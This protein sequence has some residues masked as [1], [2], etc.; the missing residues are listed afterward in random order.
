MKIRSLLLIVFACFLT[1]SSCKSKEEKAAEL[2]KQELAKTLYDFESYEPIET[3][4][5]EAYATAYN[6][7]ICYNM[8]LVI[9]YEFSKVNEAIEKAK[10]ACEYA[11][12]WGA[13]TAYSSS[14]SDKKYYKYRN[15]AKEQLD[16]V[17][18]GMAIIKSLGRTLQD[19]IAR[20]DENKQIGW[21]V[22]HRFRC[23]TR[24]GQAS[25]GDYRYVIANN[26]KKVLLREDMDDEDDKRAR[27]MIKSA[28]EGQF[29]EDETVKDDMVVVEE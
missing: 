22:K 11:D 18:N 14:Y 7:S 17:D 5:T 10:E 16:K 3:T 8:A 26:F 4:V 20:L 29:T 23:K 9:G 27:S 19:S 24:G 13:P 21:E 6:D 15:E 28:I 2:I 12:I 1:L 25:I